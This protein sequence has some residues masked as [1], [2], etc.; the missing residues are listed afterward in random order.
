MSIARFELRPHRAS[1]AYPH[2]SGHGFDEFDV[3]ENR[4][5][6]WG[7]NRERT[8]AY[9]DERNNEEAVSLRAA[10]EI[11]YSAAQI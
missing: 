11:P 6:G 2:A 5:V 1:A 9:V 10:L 4:A 8:Q 7:V 3:V